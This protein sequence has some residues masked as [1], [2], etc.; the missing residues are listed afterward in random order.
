MPLTPAERAFLSAYL[1]DVGGPPFTGPAK[2]QLATLGIRSAQE[3]PNLTNAWI[4]ETSE[5]RQT[6]ALGDPY[7]A[8]PPCP[9]NSAREVHDRDDTLKQ[10]LELG[11]GE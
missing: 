8:V 4:G 6:V 3:I 10:E 5:E 2:D 1:H 9:W 7:D 11:M